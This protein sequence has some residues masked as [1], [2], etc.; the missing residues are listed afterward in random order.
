MQPHRTMYRAC[1]CVLIIF[2]IGWS[3]YEAQGLRIFLTQK[4]PWDKFQKSSA[5]LAT[6]TPPSALVFHTN[7]SDAPLLFFHNTHNRYMAGLDPT[8]FYLANPALY[9]RYVDISNGRVHQPAEVIY[10]TF[11]TTY[12]LIV[13]PQDWNLNYQLKK[14]PR[15][16]ALFHDDESIVYRWSP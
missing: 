3:A 12:T 13:L 4:L 2:Y 5:Y 14:E 15:V 1:A 9:R 7:W 8:F 6:H 11:K 10:N 16:Q